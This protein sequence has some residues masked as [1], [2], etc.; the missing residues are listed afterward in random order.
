MGGGGVGP[1]CGPPLGPPPGGDHRDRSPAACVVME[2]WLGESDSCDATPEISTNQ[3]FDSDFDA[4]PFGSRLHELLLAVAIG[5]QCLRCPRVRL[6][7]SSLLRSLDQQSLA[8]VTV[9]Q[10]RS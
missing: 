3:Q 6:P 7:I 9:G 4:K 2:R 10:S 8:L 5:E 1:I